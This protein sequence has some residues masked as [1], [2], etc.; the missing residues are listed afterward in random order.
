MS[1]MD[2]RWSIIPLVNI[3]TYNPKIGNR[4]TSIISST[5]TRKITT[6]ATWCCHLGTVTKLSDIIAGV[7]T[8]YDNKNRNC[9]SWFDMLAVVW[10]SSPCTKT[11]RLWWPIERNSPNT[12]HSRWIHGSFGRI[13]WPTE[14]SSLSTLNSRLDLHISLHCTRRCH[15]F[16]PNHPHSVVQ[17]P[18]EP[19]N[20]AHTRSKYKW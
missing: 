19:D 13:L 16:H 1:R 5:Q 4:P 18:C 14:C 12:W 8:E 20:L 2:G 10:I 9:L 3:C 11:H 17:H 7:W 15:Q 6:A